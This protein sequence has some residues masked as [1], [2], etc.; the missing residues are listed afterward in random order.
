MLLTNNIG[1]VSH[2]LQTSVSI[3]LHFMAMIFENNI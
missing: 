1:S 2:L 3:T